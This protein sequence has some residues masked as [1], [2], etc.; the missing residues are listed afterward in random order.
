MLIVISPAKT[1]N[2]EQKAKTTIYSEND[3]L[4]RAEKLVK[5]LKKYR[6]EDLM[7]LMNVSQK[8]ALLNQQRFSEW[9]RPFNLD[10][11]KQAIMA[12]QGDVY[13]GLDAESLSE[14]ELNFAQDHLR[15]LS[16]LYGVLR[17]LDLIQAY[18]LEMG[19]AL[20][21]A[22]F[23]NLYDFWGDKLTFKINQALKAQNDKI[24]I[25][26]AS[27]EYF[28]VVNKKKLKGEIITPVFKDFKNGQYKTISFF[29]KK[30]RGLMSRFIIQNEIQKPEDLIH[31]NSEAYAY[32]ANESSTNQLVFL[33]G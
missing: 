21:T 27:N 13:L 18:R 14:K 10:N 3:F 28:K 26:L 7:V 12:F 16:G 2:F 32:S 31:F 23:K 5:V 1:L 24:L 11:A 33:R 20:Q 19:T 22:T 30:A 29:A 9:K 17:P 6:A 25:N 4:P 15:I 8:I